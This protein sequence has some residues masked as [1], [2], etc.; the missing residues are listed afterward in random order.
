MDMYRGA[1]LQLLFEGSFINA[2]PVACVA[3]MV[4]V[5]LYHGKLSAVDIVFA[6]LI[7]VLFHAWA[8]F[9]AKKR[10]L[11]YLTIGIGVF[12]VLH[13][14]VGLCMWLS[15]DTDFAESLAKAV[16]NFGIFGLACMAISGSLMCK[17]CKA[18]YDG[19]PST[20]AS[21][22]NTSVQYAAIA[23]AAL[24]ALLAGIHAGDIYSELRLRK[25]GY[26]HYYGACGASQ[27]MIATRAAFNTDKQG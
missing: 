13:S 12:L 6:P 2:L 20:D 10:G 16:G 24:F 1:P 25:H 8:V 11:W 26:N 17:S 27:G 15:M 22:L 7:C 5:A 18:W 23:L 3:V 21:A 14:L 9:L 4:V 19:I